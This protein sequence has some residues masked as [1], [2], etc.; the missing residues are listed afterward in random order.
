MYKAFKAAYVLY[1]SVKYIR[2][3]LSD[4]LHLNKTLK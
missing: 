3:N 4:K 2:L 1:T